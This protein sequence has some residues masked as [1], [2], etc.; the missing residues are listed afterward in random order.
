MKHILFIVLFSFGIVGFVLSKGTSGNRFADPNNNDFSKYESWCEQYINTYEVKRY[1]GVAFP[2]LMDVPRELNDYL[3]ESA[4]K[5]D[6]RLLKYAATIALII[7]AEVSKVS[8]TST[9]LNGMGAEDNG[10]VELLLKSSFEDFDEEGYFIIRVRKLG[11]FVRENSIKLSKEDYDYVQEKF[12]AYLKRKN[13]VINDC[14]KVLQVSDS[15]VFKI[16]PCDKIK[17]IEFETL[18]YISMDDVAKDLEMCSNLE[19]IEI[20]HPK[21]CLHTFF[22]KDGVLYYSCSLLFYPP[23]KRAKFIELPDDVSN[24]EAKNNPY[25]QE[26]RFTNDHTEF[27]VNISNCKNIRKIS[28]PNKVLYQKSDSLDYIGGKNIRV[29]EKEDLKLNE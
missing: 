4:R 19:S 14:S 21:N 24:F 1:P 27:F 20:K 25:I 26:V 23:K 13:Y 3:M 12:I 5:G 15:I 7:D 28:T 18:D 17:K 10:F 16:T 9:D 29:N 8:V 2:A 6:F 11:D 22:T